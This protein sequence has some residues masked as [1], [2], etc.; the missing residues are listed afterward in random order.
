MERYLEW[1][2]ESSENNSYTRPSRAIKN[3]PQKKSSTLDDR[4]SKITS[5]FLLLLLFFQR[6]KKTSRERERQRTNP[7]IVLGQTLA[8]PPVGDSI[9]WN[10]LLPT[11]S[12]DDTPPGDSL[13]S[14][15]F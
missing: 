10:R 2:R 1:R 15:P 13:E 5:L 11:P 8:V 9:W 3:P 4:E 6:K 7:I 14:S 12:K